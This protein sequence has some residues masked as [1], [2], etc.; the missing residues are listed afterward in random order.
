MIYFK[1][2]NI[3]VQG[4]NMENYEN[5][6]V[7][8]TGGESGIGY[9][10]AKAFG[11]EGAQLVIASNRKD[12]ISEA[13]EKL[14][15][16]GYKAEGTVCD[17]T[18]YKDV[19]FLADFAWSI[20]GQVDVLLNNAGI[21]QYPSRLLDMEIKNFKEVMDVNL[22]GTVHGVSVFGRRFLKQGTPA[23][24]YNV[25]SEN[26]FFNG[27]P[28]GAAYVASKHAVLAVSEALAEETPDNIEISLI[29][30]GL[31]KT[32]MTKD[33]PLGMEPDE[34]VSIIMPQLKAGNSY[35][36]S[37]SY[38]IERIK[39]RYE[40]IKQAY[41]TYAPR[42]EDDIKYDLKNILSKYGK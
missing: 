13:V 34:F 18:D 9:A 14:K 1:I 37:H 11:A 38:N 42:Q 28:G 41:N 17:V 2:L 12:K 32:E 3:I 20:F 6:T 5:K 21:R 4:N 24:I 7:V 15:N 26:S 40:T 19:E 25:G 29:V 33:V 35:C 39:E 23:A 36:V 30:P 16:A 22:Y 27:V 10:F 8:I 31:V